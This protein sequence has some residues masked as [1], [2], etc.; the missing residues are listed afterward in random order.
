[1]NNVL[2]VYR[3]S[4]P[5]DVAQIVPKCKLSALIWLQAKSRPVAVRLIPTYTVRKIVSA[6][7]GLWFILNQNSVRLA[8]RLT[9]VQA[10]SCFKQ[11]DDM[12]VRSQFYCQA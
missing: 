10:A 2:V 9:S 6:K 5:G 7:A 11:T 1:M 12:P 4:E 3:S 8:Y